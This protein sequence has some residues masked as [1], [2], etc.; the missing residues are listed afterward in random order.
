MTAVAEYEQDLGIRP[1]TFCAYDIDVDPLIDL[2]APAARTEWRV[3]EAD[4]VC[5]WKQIALIESGMP[6]TWSH[7]E[8][9]MASGAAG[10]RVPSTRT[11]GINVVLWRWNA[12]TGQ[13]V[14]ALDPL[15]D[16]PGR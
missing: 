5:A 2:A 8:R 1:G 14:E 6:P 13:R 16:L 10:V 9:L 4:T 15:N 7:A 12:E 11:G 3:P